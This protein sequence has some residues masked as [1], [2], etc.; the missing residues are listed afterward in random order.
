MNLRIRQYREQ[1][2]LTQK[3]FAKAIRKSVGTIQSWEGSISFPNAE[4]IW[5]MCELFGC[6]PN[7]LLGWYDTHPRGETPGLTQDESSV[8][9]KYRAL[10]PTSQIAA[11]AMLDGLV[12]R[13]KVS[14]SDSDQSAERISA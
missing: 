10:A 1:M 7:T 5:R 6:D 4:S 2:G 3:Q 11:S 12:V 9:S 14:E 8:L 13:A